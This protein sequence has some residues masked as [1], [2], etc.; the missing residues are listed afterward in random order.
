MLHDPERWPAPIVGVLKY[1]RSIPTLQRQPY[2]LEIWEVCLASFMNPSR[3][4]WVELKLQPRPVKGKGKVVK[5]KITPLHLPWARRELSS[6]TPALDFSEVKHTFPQYELIKACH[7]GRK[8]K[9]EN[10]LSNV[11][12]AATFLCEPTPTSNPALSNSL[13][14]ISAH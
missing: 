5:V 1:F 4:R 7:T 14:R 3:C 10:G 9:P 2:R 12:A 8:G 6:Q 13:G 11:N